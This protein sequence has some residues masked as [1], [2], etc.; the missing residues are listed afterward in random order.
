MATLVVVASRP[1]D[2]AS[3]TAS[4][5]ERRIVFMSVSVDA[6]QRRTA[7]EDSHRQIQSSVNCRTQL[8]LFRAKCHLPDRSR[9][10]DVLHRLRATKELEGGAMQVSEEVLRVVHRVER[11]PREDQDK[12]LKMVDLLTLVPVD[13]RDESQRMLRELL[14]R[15]PSTKDECVAGLDDVIAYL[16]ENVPDSAR[17][18]SFLAKL[19]YR[20]TLKARVV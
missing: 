19:K 3:N 18:Q 17:H 2:E 7:S 12:I 4:A 14:E 6:M 5:S 1:A 11:L 9:E 15:D 8:Q 10:I 13:V 16:E 20:S